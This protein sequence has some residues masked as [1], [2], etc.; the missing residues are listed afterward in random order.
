MR[1]II[2]PAQGEAVTIL[3]VGR[4]RSRVRLVG[5]DSTSSNHWLSYR[6]EPKVDMEVVEIEVVGGVEASSRK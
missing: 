2:R 5:S 3:A 4:G 1:Y 6:L